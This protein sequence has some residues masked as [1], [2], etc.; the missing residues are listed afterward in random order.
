MKL[1]KTNL[2]R[3]KIDTPWHLSAGNII[4]DIIRSE[5]IDYDAYP[6]LYEPI[7]EFEGTDKHVCLGDKVWRI[8]NKGYGAT[9]RSVSL[10]P[11]HINNDI[12]LF[13]TSDLAEEYLYTMEEKRDKTYSQQSIYGALEDIALFSNID[14]EKESV[15]EIKRKVSII[16]KRAK[17]ALNELNNG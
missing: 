11:V 12:D 8:D 16:N 15:S 3:T 13:P 4:N 17:D 10:S 9:V 2:Y 5:S 6:D 1:I 14:I 7:Y